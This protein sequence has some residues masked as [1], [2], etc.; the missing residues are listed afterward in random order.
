MKVPVKLVLIATLLL[1]IGVSAIQGW[2]AV[3]KLAAVNSDVKEMAT[4]WLPS[5]RTLGVFKYQV[6]RVRVAELRLA[7]L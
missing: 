5:V 7:S 1:M 2:S 4:N 6:A 3:S